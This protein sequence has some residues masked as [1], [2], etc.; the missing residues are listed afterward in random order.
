MTKKSFKLL[1]IKSQKTFT[2]IVSKMT[3][4]GK[5]TRGLG[6]NVEL[7]IF[8]KLKKPVANF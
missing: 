6:L 5:K 7:F 3:V 4:L 2:V 1:F 8:V